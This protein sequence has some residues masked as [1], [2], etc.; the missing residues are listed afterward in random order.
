VSAAPH[1][2]TTVLGSCVAVCIYDPVRKMGGMNHYM[3]PL[4][5]GEGLASAKYGNIAIEKLISQMEELG[6]ERKNLYAKVF[7]GASQVN[8]S[9]KIGERNVH[10]AKTMLNEMRINIV[11]ESLNGEK[12]RKIIFNTYTGEVRMKYVN[13]SLTK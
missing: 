8:Y 4:W 10:V 7:G 13:S 1:L 5:N 12:G 11:A 3:L 6:S 2:I 9:M